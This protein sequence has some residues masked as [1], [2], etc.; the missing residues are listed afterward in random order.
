MDFQKV[1]QYKKKFLQ[2]KQN[3][4][5]VTLEKNFTLLTGSSNILTKNL[6]SKKARQVNNKIIQNM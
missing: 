5:Q 4:H 6:T 2:L 1:T 3:I